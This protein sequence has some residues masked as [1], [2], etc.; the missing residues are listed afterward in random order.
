ME[1]LEIILKNI[2]K[3]YLDQIVGGYII[4][5]KTDIISSYFLIKK[6]TRILAMQR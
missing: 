1:Y 3:S 4:L 2:K 5:D 6:I